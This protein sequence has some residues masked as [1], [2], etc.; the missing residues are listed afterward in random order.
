MMRQYFQQKKLNMIEVFI[1]KNSIDSCISHDELDSVN[2]VLRKYE[3]LK[4]VI[5]NPIKN[6]VDF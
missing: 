1:S 3:Y 6:H 2:N 5:K 4:E